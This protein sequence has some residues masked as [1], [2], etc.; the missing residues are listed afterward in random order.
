MSQSFC[1]DAQK[2]LDILVHKPKIGIV[3]MHNTCRF[4]QL[5]A[6]NCDR[7]EVRR[8]IKCGSVQPG[9]ATRVARNKQ[10]KSFRYEFIDP[11]LALPLIT[12]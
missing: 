8:R 6:V 10:S 4:K 9:V 1:C 12:T 7:E 3:A 2:E 11:Q 5:Q